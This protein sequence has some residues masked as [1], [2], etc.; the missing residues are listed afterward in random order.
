VGDGGGGVDPR[1][2]AFGIIV[3]DRAAGSNQQCGSLT[4][5]VAAG[6]VLNGT[7]LNGTVLNG[8]VLNGTVLNGTVLNG[9]AAFGVFL[10]LEVLDSDFLTFL[11]CHII[12]LS[13]WFVLCQ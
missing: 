13:G 7:V 12:F 9:T 11:C 3:K 6:T 5:L 10:G 4:F 8:T 2:I 1:K